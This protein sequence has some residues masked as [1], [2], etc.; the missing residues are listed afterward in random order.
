MNP[1]N[2]PFGVT[3]RSVVEPTKRL[4]AHRASTQIV[5][6]GFLTVLS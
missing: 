4:A 3:G 6:E 5:D 2:I 1:Q